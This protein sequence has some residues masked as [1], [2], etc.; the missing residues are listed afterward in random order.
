M[1]I[2]GVGTIFQRWNESTNKWEAVANITN[3]SGPSATRNTLDTTTLDTEGGYRTFITGFR[4]AGE[5]TMSM[6]F[7]RTAYDIMFGDFESDDP[8][9]YEIILPDEE[10]T[11]IEFEGFVTGVPLTIPEGVATMEVTIKISG[12][13]AVNSGAESSSPGA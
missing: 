5:I 13:I 8:H 3:I 11:S 9:N 6:N 4:D 2:S 12:P 7:T 10:N 1:A